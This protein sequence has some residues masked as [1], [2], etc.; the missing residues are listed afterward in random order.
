MFSTW[1]RLKRDNVITPKNENKV[2]DI[3]QL[4]KNLPFVSE[5]FFQTQN[6]RI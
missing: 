2:I 6:F 1:Q 4:Q 3:F 5:L